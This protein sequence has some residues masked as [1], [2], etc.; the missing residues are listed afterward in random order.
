MIRV[1]RLNGLPIVINSDLIEHVE[2][3]PDTVLTLT[4]GTSLMVQESVDRVVQEVVDFR[5]RIW[6]GLLGSLD[7]PRSQNGGP[8]R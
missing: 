3:T 4:T 6:T 5:R 8:V 1:T 2:A 7:P